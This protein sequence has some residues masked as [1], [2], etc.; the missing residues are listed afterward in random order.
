MTNQRHLRVAGTRNLRDVGGYEAGPGRETR[1]ET[2]FRSDS[3]DKLPASSQSTI[4]DLGIRLVIDLRHRAEVESWPSVFRASPSVGYVRAPI[5]EDPPDPALTI[6]GVYRQMLD[7]H[8]G[9]IAAAVRA[10]VQPGALPAIIGCAAGVDRT[11]VTIAVI[12]SAV[13]VPPE[14]IASDYAL[15]VASYAFDAPESGLDDWRAGPVDID[16]APETMAAT[17]DYLDRRY[18]GGRGFL[19]ERGLTDDEVDRLAELLTAPVT[20]DQPV[21]GIQRASQARAPS[22]IEAE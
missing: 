11:G 5:F 21:S 16:A 9:G 15:S 10:I 7:E 13:G 8:G 12:L 2:L 6:V 20:G 3:L 14:V 19:I 18:G 17:L 1:W 22:R 4:A